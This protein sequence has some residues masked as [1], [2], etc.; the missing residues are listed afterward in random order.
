M[1]RRYD[2]LLLIVGLLLLAAPA[3]SAPLAS[4][5]SRYDRCLALVHTSPTE[6]IAAANAMRI[7]GGGVAA[8][9]CLALAQMAQLDYPAALKSFEAAAQAAEAEH[10][11]QAAALWSQGGNAAIIAGRNDLAVQYL[12]TGIAASGGGIAEAEMRVDR[13]RALVELKQDAEA[14]ADLDKATKLAPDVADGWLLKAT[15]AR[16]MKDYRTAEAALLEAAKRDAD[17]PDI[18]LEAGNLAAA[19]GNAQLAHDA[20]TAVVTAA[21]G[22]DA[23]KAAAAA[24]AANK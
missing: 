23:G 8:R 7:D 9:H 11:G 12:T 5:R 24:L 22:S 1:N 10:D 4:E 6:A 20:W 19:Q 15:L 18:Q 13:A 21:P 17:S 14:A 3:L 2:A 16:R